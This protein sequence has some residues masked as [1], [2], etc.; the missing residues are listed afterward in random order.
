M[1]PA[2][3]LIDLTRSVLTGFRFLLKT[4]CNEETTQSIAPDPELTLMMELLTR[5]L[6]VIKTVFCMFKGYKKD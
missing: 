6:R 1:F 2:V 4:N 3:V 5:T